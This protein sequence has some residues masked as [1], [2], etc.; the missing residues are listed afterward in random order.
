MVAQSVVPRGILKNTVFVH[1]NP[2]FL[3]ALN[4]CSGEIETAVI[5]AV[6][7]VDLNVRQ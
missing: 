5:E 7:N 2:G 1:V 6:S 4:T 3:E